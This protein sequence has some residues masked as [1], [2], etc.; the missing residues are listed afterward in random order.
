MVAAGALGPLPGLA[1]ARLFAWLA[2]V[3]PWLF[4]VLAAVV[5]AGGF[6]V[7]RWYGEWRDRLDSWPLL[8]MYRDIQAIRFLQVLALFDVHAPKRGW[9][10]ADV[11]RMCQRLDDGVIDAS[12]FDTGLLDPPV[13]KFLAHAV[14]A[15]G[16]D[17]RLHAARERVAHTLTL[18]VA[19][20]ATLWRWTLLQG[21]G[22]LALGIAGWHFAAI[23]KLRRGL[24]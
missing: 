17:A 21:A 8:R 4:P 10:A 6:A 14:E 5:A 18:S 1:N 2:P 11:R 23:D 19:I 12:S 7:S 20:E 15:Q 16:L 24:A 13:Y 3:L 9:L 22:T